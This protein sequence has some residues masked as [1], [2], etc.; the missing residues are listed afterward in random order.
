MRGCVVAGTAAEDDDRVILGDVPVCD[1]CRAPIFFDGAPCARTRSDYDGV[2]CLSAEDDSDVRSRDSEDVD[3]FCKRC[4]ETRGCH[5]CHA[6]ECRKC[7]EEQFQDLG[8]S[9]YVNVG[10][11]LRRCLMCNSFVCGECGGECSW[12]GLLA[13]NQCGEL[14][15]VGCDACETVATNKADAFT[16]PENWD[17]CGVCRGDG[18]DCGSGYDDKK[19]SMFARGAARRKAEEEARV[20]ARRASRAFEASLK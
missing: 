20:K 14:E 7:T 8:W 16:M 2:V 18:V 6:L 5:I 1:G 19:C 9:G 4:I 11:G 13:C 17:V 10:A 12:C 15:S 3:M